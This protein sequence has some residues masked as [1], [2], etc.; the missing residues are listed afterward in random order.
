[1]TLSYRTRRFLTALGIIALILVLLAV[2]VWA[3]WLLWLDRYVVYTRDGAKFDFS[4]TLDYQEGELAVPPED[5]GQIS[6]YYN[7]GDNTLN[8]NTEMTILSGYFASADMLSSTFELVR[9][10]MELLPADTPVMID[11][12]D[13]YGNF[14]YDTD[15][16]KISSSINLS[17]MNDLL[18]Y[19][20][21]ARFYTIARIPSFR[22]YQYAYDHP[23]IG[24]THSSGKY[25]FMDDD[26]AYWLDPTKNGTLSYLMDIVDEIKALGFDEVVFDDF[27]YPDTDKIYFKGNRQTALTEAAQKLVDGCSQEGFTISFTA[28]SPTFAVPEGRTRIYLEGQSA[29]DAKKITEQSGFEN[30]NIRLVFVTEV[31]DTRFDDFSVLRPITAAQLEEQ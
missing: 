23:S 29:G 27:W 15:L 5:D 4:L 21:A 11:L 7:E 25:V 18:E 30:P 12:K 8:V 6:I 28:D 9:S 14:Y 19:M 22:D 2:L 13:I 24:L 20:Q 1:M 16:G 10:Q 31:N 3:V 26:R 17:D